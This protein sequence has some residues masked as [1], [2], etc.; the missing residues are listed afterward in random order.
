[1]NIV[2][3]GT[4]PLSYSLVMHVAIYTDEC[5]K[6]LGDSYLDALLSSSLSFFPI[7][8]VSQLS[9]QSLEVQGLEK[10]HLDDYIEPQGIRA[11][12]L[13]SPRPKG[14]ECTCYF[15]I[16]TGPEC[17]PIP[18]WSAFQPVEVFDTETEKR[19]Q[20]WLIKLY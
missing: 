10:V 5:D 8:K 14:Q 2:T 19:L 12:P 15:F 9:T 6:V 16:K 7:L 17:G 11:E 18:Q 4:L 13:P 20:R 3:N 1:M